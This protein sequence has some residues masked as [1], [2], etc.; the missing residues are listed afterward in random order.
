MHHRSMIELLVQRG[1]VSCSMDICIF[2]K[3]ATRQSWSVVSLNIATASFL[4]FP[5]LT[6]FLEDFLPPPL[7]VCSAASL[8]LLLGFDVLVIDLCL[9]VF[10]LYIF[11][12]I[13]LLLY[14]YFFNYLK[15]RINIHLFLI[16]D[17]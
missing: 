6:I 7:F 9:T 13:F 16:L 1:I 4:D 10:I 17:I 5:F 11:K 8:Y 12:I 3:F 14:L 15:L 2:L